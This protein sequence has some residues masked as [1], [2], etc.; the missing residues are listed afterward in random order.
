[1][2]TKSMKYLF[3]FVLALW[4]SALSAQSHWSVN[5]SDYSGHMTIYYG[6]K[7]GDHVLSDIS[8]YEVAAFVNGEC[9]GVGTIENHD[10]K[11]YGQLLVYVMVKLLPLSTMIKVHRRRRILITEQ[12]LFPQME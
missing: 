10:G 1:M 3:S 9:R 8:N 7:S 2:N 12:S 6:L 4:A 11:T 5:P